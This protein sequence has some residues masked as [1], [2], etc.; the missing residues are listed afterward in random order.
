M[1]KLSIV[2]VAFNRPNSLE[3][4]LNSLNKLIIFNG[5]KIDLHISI[6]RKRGDPNNDLTIEKAEE[7]IWKY[8]EKIVDVKKE[9][10]GLKKHVIYCGNLTNKYDNIIVLEDDLVVSPLMVQYAKQAINFYSNDDSISG[11]GLYSFQRNPLNNYPFY[12]LN[13]GSDVYF[14]QYACSWGQLWSKAKWHH[15]YEWYELN[16]ENDFMDNEKIPDYIKKWGSKSWLKYYTFYCILNN[17]FFVYPQNGFT[18]N[19]TELG[20]HNF[21]NTNAY[22][23]NMYFNNENV[24]FK[25]IELNKALNIYDAYFENICLKK[26]M[27]YDSDI[28]SDT[29]GSKLYFDNNKLLLS[30]KKYDYKILSSYSLKMYPVEHN[31]YYNIQGADLFLYDLSHKEKNKCKYDSY[32]LLK[33]YFKLDLLSSKNKID[34]IKNNFIFL[35]HRLFR[36]GKK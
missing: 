13:N 30:T 33:Y 1:T 10:Y 31:L 7:F 16:K 3:R 21:D 35:L 6:D 28:E 5:E 2:I 15:F 36:R 23:C 27:N 32:T 22:Q 34:L 20:T 19:F 12:P 9:N 18:T 8:G 4:L 24:K 25:F 17:K 26:I 14:M 11:I 29:Y